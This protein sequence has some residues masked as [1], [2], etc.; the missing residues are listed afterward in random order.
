M[1]DDFVDDFCKR[2]LNLGA[3]RRSREGVLWILR[4]GVSDEPGSS[5][6]NLALVWCLILFT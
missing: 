4:S 6:S 2:S 1:C 3:A 5:R